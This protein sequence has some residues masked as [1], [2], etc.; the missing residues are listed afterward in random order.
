MGQTTWAIVNHARTP[1]CAAIPAGNVLEQ[2]ADRNKCGVRSGRPARIDAETMQHGE[3]ELVPE[4]GLRIPPEGCDALRA[5]AGGAT[6]YQK[7]TVRSPSRAPD[8]AV[9]PT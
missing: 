8:L 2:A 1:D 7:P 9:P 5:S 4:V 6:K 3:V